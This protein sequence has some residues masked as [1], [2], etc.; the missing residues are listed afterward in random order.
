MDMLTFSRYFLIFAFCLNIFAFAFCVYAQVKMNRINKWMLDYFNREDE[1]SRLCK[2]DKE[3]R[4]ER[5]L[6]R[7]RKA[8]IAK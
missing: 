2:L 4:I 3:Q 6:Q 1:R 8:R 5:E 7:I